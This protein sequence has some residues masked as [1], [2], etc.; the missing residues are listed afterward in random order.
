MWL[1]YP[2]S[3]C[4][5]RCVYV[6]CLS[7]YRLLSYFASFLF[8]QL[9]LLPNS[10]CIL[11]TFACPW[12]PTILISIRGINRYSLLDFFAL[13]PLRLLLKVRLWLPPPPLWAATANLRMDHPGVSDSA[14]CLGYVCITQDC[15]FSKGNIQ[16]NF[17]KKDSKLWYNRKFH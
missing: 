1:S 4:L 5:L 17:L 12:P 3:E 2:V 16:G 10:F 14:W 13:S 9:F 6:C 8:I 11:L 15:S 7:R